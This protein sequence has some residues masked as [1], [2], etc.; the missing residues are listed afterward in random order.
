MSIQIQRI[1]TLCNMLNLSGIATAHEALAQEA[2]RKESSYSDFL[3][4]CLQSEQDTRQQR[5]RST[6]LKMAGFP[7]MRQLE[8][9]DFK[10]ASGAPKKQIEALATMSFIHRKENIVLLGPSGVGKTHIAIALGYLATLNGFKTR[11]ITAADLLL[12]LD[13]ARRQGR[14][15][16]TMQRSVN[17][18]SLLIIDEIGYLPMAAEQANLFFQVV[19]NRYEKGSIILT[20][21]LSFGQW[22]ETFAGNTALTSA[23]LDRILHH[24]HVIQIKGDSYRLK[25]KRKAGI[26][27]TDLPNDKELVG[28]F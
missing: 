21:N 8:E 20:S 9:Y 10:F 28:Q 27:K 22:G 3:E 2:A 1:E 14:L 17:S 11:F 25:E 6:L 24:A 13:A 15:K 4:Y 26:I 18:P 23:M 5:S 16:Q 19:A 7:V 12:Q